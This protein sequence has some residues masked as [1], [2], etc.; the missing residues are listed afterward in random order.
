MYK[1]YLLLLRLTDELNSLLQGSKLIH[2][3]TQEKDKIIFE[4]DSNVSNIFLEVSTNINFPYIIPRSSY[5]RAKKNTISFFQ[6]YLPATLTDIKIANMERIIRL[7]FHHFFINIFFTGQL[8]NVLLS[9]DFEILDSFKDCSEMK[10]GKYLTLLNKSE[11]ISRNGFNLPFEFVNNQNFSTIKLN[12]PFVDKLFLEELKSFHINLSDEVNVD[13]LL[14]T[15]NKLNNDKLVIINNKNTGDIHL[16][17]ESFKNSQSRISPA[18][19]SVISA[20]T[21]LIK[22]KHQQDDRHEYIEKIKKNLEKDFTSLNRKITIL[23]DRIK[24]NAKEIEFRKI[25]NLLLANLQKIKK[26]DQEVEINDF[27][28]E[29]NIIKINLDKKLTPQENAEYYFD[30]AKSA[31][32]SLEKDK[33]L[34]INAKNRLSIILEY[35]NLNI[36]ELSKTELKKIMNE[37]KINYEKSSSSGKIKEP[38][39]KHYLIDE[40]YHVYVGNDAKNNDELTLHYAKQN[41]LWFHARSLPGSH[42]ILRCDNISD[43]IPKNIIEKTASIAAFHSKGK[44]AKLIPVTYTLKKYV[45]KRKGMPAGQVVLQ[46]EKV[47]IVKPEIP[48]GCTF[49]AK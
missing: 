31:K 8:T 14:Q 11:F 2:A 44:T 45:T 13:W 26:G 46:R 47:I 4:F 25:G 37:L 30:K 19:N 17:P 49:A 24:N 3:F 12:L 35:K 48:A 5:K 6:K 38:N 1:N 28:N 16:I 41:D 33:L 7:S 36:D 15:I 22:Y 39:F 34:L 20:L 21:E 27:D 43:N 42:V 29:N 40:T 23:N 18:F 9:N 32:T 10:R